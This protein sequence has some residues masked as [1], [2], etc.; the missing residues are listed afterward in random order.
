[1]AQGKA[2]ILPRLDCNGAFTSRRPAGTFFP[3]SP[4]S[5]SFHH[6][7]SVYHSPA[8]LAWAELSRKTEAKEK[9]MLEGTYEKRQLISLTGDRHELGE[10]A[11]F[12]SS[13]VLS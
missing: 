6:Q 5:P 12:I 4:S 11:F 2:A 7:Y 13:L 1:V 3:S 10:A 9:L 8:G